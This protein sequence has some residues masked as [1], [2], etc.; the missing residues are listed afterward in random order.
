M[1]GDPTAVGQGTTPVETASSSQVS[2]DA[3]REDR[4]HI[5][6]VGEELQLRKLQ[7]AHLA[8]WDKGGDQYLSK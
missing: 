5:E 3:A 6:T 1:V 7:L 4:P 8:A 2:T